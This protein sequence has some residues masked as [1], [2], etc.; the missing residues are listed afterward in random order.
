MHNKIAD[1]FHRTHNH[2]LKLRNAR[3]RTHLST[4]DDACVVTA[5]RA[6]GR[7]QVGVLNLWPRSMLLLLPMANAMMSLLH[8]RYLR[9]SALLG[10]CR[11]MNGS[12]LA[13]A[14]RH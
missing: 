11:V 6:C 9:R 2:L 8:R 3:K 13:V 7:V 10:K 14:S 12:V 4:R 5:R 1:T